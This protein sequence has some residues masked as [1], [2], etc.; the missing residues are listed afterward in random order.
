[1]FKLLLAFIILIG[2]IAFAEDK[3]LTIASDPWCPFSCEKESKNE[4]I[5]IELAR[6]AFEPLGYKIKYSVMTFLRTL[7]EL[8]DGNVDMVSS[9][10]ETLDSSNFIKGSESVFPTNFTFFT[11]KDS[12]FIYDEKNEAC[13]DGLTIGIN[14]SDSLNGLF[15]GSIGSYINKNLNNS[16]KIKKVYGENVHIQLLDMLKQDRIDLYIDT[17]Q[18]ALYYINKANLQKEI[19]KGIP[20]NKP[21]NEYIG[22]SPA[23]ANGKE[24]MV[25]FDKRMKELK[26]DGTYEKIMKKY[27][28]N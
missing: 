21:V 20:I 6:A 17:E 5:A 27:G 12:K 15:T 26:K 18:V 4:G 28:L 19:M 25:L 9:V 8:K 16:S 2:S 11:R 7:Q 10:D 24:L 14:G 1:M 23:K 22:F 13:F 3:E